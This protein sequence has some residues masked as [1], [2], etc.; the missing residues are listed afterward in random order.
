MKNLSIPGLAL[1]VLLGGACSPRRGENGAD[2]ADLRPVVVEGVRLD[3]T[4]EPVLT[5]LE[6]GGQLRRLTIWIGE[7]QAQSIHV[8]LSEID[9]PRPNTHDLMVDILGGLERELRRVAI[10]ELRD[11]TYYALIDI[12]GTGGG[13][14]LDARPSDAIALAVRTGAPIF[15]DES[16]LASG[17]PGGDA[18]GSLD[19]D[20]RPPRSAPALPRR[21]SHQSRAHGGV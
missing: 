7:E 21:I 5:L 20:W 13:V 10:T 19:A 15:V 1:A 11:G 2:T 9:L 6:K 18:E 4:G 12:G 16:V 17:T 8:A 3:L 14:Q